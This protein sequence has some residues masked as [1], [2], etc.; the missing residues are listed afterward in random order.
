MAV[1]SFPRKEIEKHFKL[2]PEVVD[3]I[4]MFGTPVES[5]SKESLDV[6]IFPNRPDLISLQGFTRAI[7]A[8]L[9]KDKGLRNYKVS[10]PLE[11]YKVF[12]KSTVKSVRPYTACAIIRGLNLDDQKIKEIVYMQ[13][14]LHNTFGRQRKKIAIGI[15]PLEKIQLP[16]TYEALPTSKIKF[17]PLDGKREMTGPEI[18]LWHPTGKE[19]AH[20]LKNENKFPVFRDSLGKVLSMPPIIN[21]QEMGKVTINTK[22]VFVECSGSNLPAL[23]HT[24]NMVATTLSDMGGKIYQL[25]IIDSEKMVTPDLS[26][27]K[28]KI[29]LERTNKILGIN[30]T[31]KELSVCLEKMG[32]NY[33]NKTVL[34]PAWRTDVLHEIDLIEDIAISYGYENFSPQIPNIGGIGEEDKK[35]K[36]KTKI[37][38]ILVG[39]NLLEIS[40]YHFIKKDEAK[41]MKR[42][43]IK[44]EEAKT[45]YKNLRPNLRIPLLRTLSEN[46][47]AEYPQKVFEIG[48]TFVKR[49]GVDEIVEKEKLIIGITP[50]KFTEAKQNLDYLMRML[51][52]S[53]EI[54]E[55]VKNN[56]IEGRTGKIL[57][58]NKEIGYMGEVHPNTLRAWHLK[59]PLCIIEIDTKEIYKIL[60]IK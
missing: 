14:K 16:I 56:L 21:S 30:L 6:E 48:T 31:E 25:D 59:M 5:L 43:G 40:T 4:N 39:L 13:E 55:T 28:M 8:Y 38:E 20:L 57:V 42:P 22:D 60:K 2:T 17:F 45:E 12:V 7:R 33:K 54:K 58:N 3:K 26:P 37:S 46:T 41:K 19:Y 49:E 47:D 11:N 23:N 50:G 44:I 36:L 29:S 32:Y 18:L 52:I 9:G 53:Y 1:I 15:Y 24:I 27:K 10:K 51:D 35:A 34:V